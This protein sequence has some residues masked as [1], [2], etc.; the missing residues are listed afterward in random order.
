MSIVFH[1]KFTEASDT[2]L[3]AHTPDIGT[4]WTKHSVGTGVIQAKAANDRAECNTTASPGQYWTDAPSTTDYVVVADITIVDETDASNGAGLWARFEPESTYPGALHGYLLRS[5]QGSNVWQLYQIFN[6][7]STLLDT[8][9]E[10]FPAATTTFEV[11]LDTRV[12]A[13]NVEIRVK[14]DGVPQTWVTAGSTVLTDSSASKITATHRAGLWQ[15]G[16]ATDVYVDN[17]HIIELSPTAYIQDTFTN[18]VTA[19]LHDLTPEIGTAWVRNTAFGA[20][21]QVDAANDYVD[22]SITSGG[23]TYA[24]PAPPTANYTVKGDLVMN[25]T[26]AATG[27]GCCVRIA[28][29]TKDGYLLRSKQSTSQWILGRYNSGVWTTLDTVSFTFT[30]GNTYAF[31]LAVSTNGGGDVEFTLTVDSVLKTWVTSGTTTATDSS[32][33]KV[34]SI[35]YAA[36]WAHTGNDAGVDNFIVEAAGITVTDFEDGRVFQRTSPSTTTSDITISGTYTGPTAPTAIQARVVES[37]T[38][39]PISGFDWTT[40]DSAPASGLYS[41]TLSGVPQGGWYNVQVRFSNDT[42]ITAGGTN[43]WGIG[44]LYGVIGQSHAYRWFTDGVS[45]PAQKG[46]VLTETGWNKIG[47]TMQGAEGFVDLLGAALGVPVGL[48]DYGISGDTITNWISGGSSYTPFKDGVTAAGGKLEGIC[49]L[50]GP[51][52]SKT[53]MSQATYEGHLYNDAGSVIKTIRTDTVNASGETNLPFVVNLHGNVDHVDWTDADVETIRKAQANIADT[54]ADVYRVTMQNLPRVDYAHLTGAG[55]ETHGERFAQVFL[56]ILGSE[57]YHRGP[58]FLSA[59]WVSSTV[60][61]VTLAHNGGTDFTPT[62]GITGFEVFDNAVAATISS[63]VRQNASTV[64]LT[65]SSAMTG[66][67]TVR[68]LYGKLPTVSGVVIDNS[69][70]ALPLE[71][72]EL[73]TAPAGSA[74]DHFER[75]IM[76]GVGRGVC[77]GI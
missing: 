35:G 48:L 77:R 20:T 25:S 10:T 45:A 3:D 5:R 38:S 37:G 9:A 22:A 73:A 44:V 6:G 43:D 55:Y 13:G 63:A 18:R 17:F 75:G 7:T 16:T 2:N 12:V 4:G 57:S 23:V 68:H 64:R 11:K 1:D 60:V 26:G 14:I 56:D 29:S 39:T 46:S 72:F 66:P 65:V 50:Q 30:A 24:T 36:V 21:L 34:T 51:A 28:G 32:V 71:W 61:D 19:N 27:A 53:S 52:D 58:T 70:R 42:T 54:V 74:S 47:A 15:R 31:E 41:G 59:V 76:R 62:T 69:A 8:I 67:V 40:I 33:D 49:W